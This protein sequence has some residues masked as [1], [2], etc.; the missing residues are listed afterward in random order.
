VRWLLRDVASVLAAFL[1]ALTVVPALADGDGDGDAPPDTTETGTPPPVRA[2]FRPGLGLETGFHPNYKLDYKRDQ[3][4]SSWDHGFAF[5]YPVSDRLT[6][7]ATSSIAVRNTDAL[8]RENRQEHW[9]AGLDVGVTRALTMGIKLDRNTQADVRN[10]GASG[11]VRSSR[12]KETAD[13]SA[14]YSDTLLSG[15]TTSLSASAGL[16]KNRYS[17]VASRGSTQGVSASLGY[18]PMPGLDGSLNYSGRHSL[19]DSEQGALRSTDESVGHTLGADV[20]YTWGENTLNATLNRSTSTNEYP[21]EEQK[22]RRGQ[23]NRSTALTGSFKPLPGMDL[24]LGYSY[25]RDKS[26]YALDTA[27]ASDLMGRAVNASLNYTLAGTSL[28]GQ[29]SSEVKRNEY[30]NEQTGN[31]YGKSLVASASRDFGTRVS[32]RFNGRMTLYS[33]Q[34]DDTEA[35]NQDRDLY[36]R[37]AT[38]S[39]EYRPGGDISTAL[40]LRVREDQLV[41]I[42]TARTGDNKTTQ[43]FS[44]QPIVTKRFSRGLS[45]TQQYQLSADYTLY[46]FD[47]DRNFLVRSVGVTTELK[48]SA[49]TALEVLVSHRY[50][51]QDEGAYVRGD[52]GI[53][54]YGRN[55]ER[56][57]HTMKVSLKYKLL[58]AVSIE[59]AQDF[60]VQQKWNLFDGVRSL[61]WERH[62]TS[63]TG[64]ASAD[65]RLADG[66]T[67]K[68][69]VARTDR[70]ATTIVERQRHVW[71]ISVS[72]DRTF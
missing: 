9:T 65:Y 66:T 59:A 44:V 49:L 32:A 62:D 10:Q 60:T 58:D 69:S 15:L 70:D 63:L 61:A 52:D 2:P 19:L 8:N 21:K 33:H 67:L 29:F 54:R 53:R 56:D 26:S 55:S 27:R 12:E 22:E 11:E 13:L 38:L 68:V 47:E 46:S 34:F 45:L 1:I 18:S 4:V 16:E 39:L 71:N 42:R 51:G 41:Y 31:S 43:T 50:T 48:W 37:E 17:N 35:N 36:D 7:G 25:S 5:R 40:T 3:D 64:K 20:G 24:S 6:F 72:I 28:T 57:D 14:S 23:D 30:F